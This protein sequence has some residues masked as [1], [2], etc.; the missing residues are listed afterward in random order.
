MQK[1][2]LVV[3]CLGPRKDDSMVLIVKLLGNPKHLWPKNGALY[4]KC[5]CKVLCGEQIEQQRLNLT[6]C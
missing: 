5:N 4:I 1:A 6:K 3:S 2:N